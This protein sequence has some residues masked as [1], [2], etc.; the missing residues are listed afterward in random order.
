MNALEIPH[1]SLVS[2]QVLQE[3]QV[4]NVIGKHNNI[5]NVEAALEDYSDVYMISELCNRGELL[6]H[7]ARKEAI[8]N[9]DIGCFFAQLM[10][11]IVHC[12][13]HGELCYL[14]CILPCAALPS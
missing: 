10:Q 1:P 5:L 8:S 12:H 11:A 9:Q 6:A 4:H 7:L 13:S 2:S 14:V 3:V